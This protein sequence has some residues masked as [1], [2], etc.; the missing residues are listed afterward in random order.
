MLEFLKQPG[1]YESALFF[2]GVFTYKIIVY[3]L[4]VIH[5]YK[6]YREV[7]NSSFTI[8]ISTYL[9][10]MVGLELKERVM[11]E[12]EIDEKLIKNIIEED[13]EKI[14]HW[15]DTALHSLYSFAPKIFMEIKKDFNKES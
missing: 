10:A 5:M 12:G 9:T 6:Y 13:Q 14:D 11:R 1:I 8:L 15:R 2:A 3:V 7:G 4:G